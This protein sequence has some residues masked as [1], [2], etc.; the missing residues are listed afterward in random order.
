M[1][2]YIQLANGF[3]ST[4]FTNETPNKIIE[5]LENQF[6]GNKSHFQD[7]ESLSR[8]NTQYG[9][10]IKGGLKTF[11]CNYSI[12][13]KFDS[14]KYQVFV[15]EFV[16]EGTARKQVMLFERLLHKPLTETEIQQVVRQLTE[17]IFEHIDYNTKKNGLR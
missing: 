16:E 3:S 17:V 4:Q 5:K 14:I 9:T 12:E 10:L 1:S 6:I 2:H 13:I 8:I 7:F 15:D 11:G